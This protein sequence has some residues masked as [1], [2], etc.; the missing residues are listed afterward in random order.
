MKVAF[1]G[2]WIGARRLFIV[3]RARAAIAALERRAIER[4]IFPRILFFVSF[5]IYF[6]IGLEIQRRD[7]FK[8][9]NIF[10]NAD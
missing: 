7:G 9:W 10:F 1:V 2:R 8:P 5:L 6:W 4:E 3:L